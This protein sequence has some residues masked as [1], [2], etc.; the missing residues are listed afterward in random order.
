MI[1]IHSADDIPLVIRNQ[2]VEHSGFV[3]ACLPN[4][5]EKLGLVI[6]ETVT[7][8]ELSEEEVTIGLRKVV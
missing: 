8:G 6:K 1:F 3:V 5:P 4:R 2:H 7:G